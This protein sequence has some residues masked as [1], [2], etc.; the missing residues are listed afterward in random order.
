MICHNSVGYDAQIKD[1]L[2]K[3]AF[4]MD[5]KEIEKLINSLDQVQKSKLMN[6]L[7]N[8]S[9]AERILRTPEAQAIMKKLKG[10]K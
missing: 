8:K 7:A 1:L 2:I 4:N 10:D 5:K 9:E 3:S 6:A